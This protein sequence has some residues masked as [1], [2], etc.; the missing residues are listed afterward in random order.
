MAFLNETRT[1]SDVG[2]GRAAAILDAI[3]LAA[4]GRSKARYTEAGTRSYQTPILSTS[5]DSVV[6]M[7]HRAKRPFDSAYVDRLI[8]IP[9]PGDGSSFFE[10]LHGYSDVEAFVVRLK[11]L[12][13]ANHGWLGLHFVR[14][15]AQALVRDRVEVVKFVAARRR[16]YKRR[17]SKI[18]AHGRNLDRAREARYRLRGGLLGDPLQALAFHPGASS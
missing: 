9:A 1:M 12:A 15:L 4:E 7:L 2:R 10:D 13:R 14:E 5:N 6:A 3:M 18:V 11:G 17:A 8:D 16:A